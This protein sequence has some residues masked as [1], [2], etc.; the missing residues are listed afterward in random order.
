MEP[1]PW[2]EMILKVIIIGDPSVGKT[3]LL[4]RIIDNTFSDKYL[5]TLGVDFSFKHLEV[6]GKK[7]KLQIWDTAGQEKYRSLI[8]TYYRHT[9]GVIVV[10]D[11]D[12]PSSFKN[13]VTNWV[14]H[15]VAY[16]TGETPKLL[17]LGNKLDLVK[18]DAS[19]KSAVQVKRELEQNGKCLLRD[20]DI[21]DPQMPNG[22]G[23]EES[24]TINGGR[25]WFYFWGL[26]RWSL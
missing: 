26:V 17:I 16:I 5:S 18:G 20:L 19:R 21:N 6:S 24:F 4:R 22:S 13:V 10:F 15:L 25:A 2:F 9:N 23:S 3:S 8:T 12:S 1:K 7:I 14:G 11:L